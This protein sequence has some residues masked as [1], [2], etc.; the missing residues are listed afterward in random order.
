MS[1]FMI[2]SPHTKEECQH[3]LEATLDEGPE[4]LA[5]YEFGCASGDHTGYALVS[6]ET[7]REAR[8]MVPSFLRAKAKI[9]EVEPYTPEEIRSSHS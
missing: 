4:I 7:E 9:V 3:A 1:D 6:V 5:Q 2:S 8:L